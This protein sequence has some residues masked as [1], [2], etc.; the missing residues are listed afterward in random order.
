MEQQSYKS[1]RRLLSFED[2]DATLPNALYS[3][4]LRGMGI[5]ERKKQN[6]GIVQTSNNSPRL[7][8]LVNKRDSKLVQ[9]NG[10]VA[11]IQN[12]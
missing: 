12:Q 2:S 11:K 5:K 9:S 4:S 8:R 10:R 1:L 7:P 6:L 3:R